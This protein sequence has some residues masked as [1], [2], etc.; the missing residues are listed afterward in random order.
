[1]KEW[2]KKEILKCSSGNNTA[3]CPLRRTMNIL[4]TFSTMTRFH[5]H[6]V[7]YLVILYS[8]RNSCGRLR[9]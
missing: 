3:H 9:W 2:K 8:F 6:C 7:Y 4:N 5:N 1:M